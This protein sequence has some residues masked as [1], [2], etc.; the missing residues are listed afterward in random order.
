MRCPKCQFD[1][2]LQK[3]ECLKCGIVFSHYQQVADTP[4]THSDSA[5]NPPAA[6]L[7][8]P[9]AVPAVQVAMAAET[10]SR[11]LSPDANWLFTPADAR[12]DALK[13]LKYRIFALPLALL[14]ARLLTG[15]G[16]DMAA[17][18][19][20]MV[21]HESGHAI[22]SW[23][24]GR[25][26]VPLLWVTMHGD[27]RSWLVVV[28]VIAAIVAGGFLAWRAQRWGWVCA[29]GALLILELSLQTLTPFKQEALIVFG[30]DG[31]AMVLST[32]LMAAFYAPRES[33]LYKSWGLRWGLLVIGALA[34]MHVFRLWSGPYENIPFG[35]IEGVNLSDPSLLTTMYGWSIL[36]LVDRYVRLATVCFAAMA[37][38]YIC[39]LISAYLET[40]S[41]A[42]SQSRPLE[43]FDVDLNVAPRP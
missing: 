35:E 43:G 25:W 40:R 41:P 3:T 22:T 17:G 4:A 24:T 12:K 5:V 14:I 16:F 34:F 20:A 39:G 23:L 38:V 28:I 7:A 10:L 33:A 42:S 9:P 15:T 1:H 6:P 11:A 29:A 8:I 19:L 2:E 31:G 32:I 21:V 36:Q 18:M 27:N 37:A 26:A 30:G 13:E